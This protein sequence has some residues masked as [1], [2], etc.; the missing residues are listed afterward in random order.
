MKNTSHFIWKLLLVVGLAACLVLVYLDA[1][2]S[3]S[4]KDRQWEVP[5]RVFAR[6]LELYPGRG[7]SLA[8]LNYELD[9][10]G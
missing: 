8:D 6:P 4:F 5:A 9:L 2:V 7:L 3:T 1:L 10:L